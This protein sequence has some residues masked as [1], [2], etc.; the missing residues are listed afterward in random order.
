ML[1]KVNLNS[2]GIAEGSTNSLDSLQIM[3]HYDATIV[4]CPKANTRK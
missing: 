2:S 3:K 1:D 4:N